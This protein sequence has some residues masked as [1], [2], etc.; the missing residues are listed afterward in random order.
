MVT[1]EQKPQETAEETRWWLRK[2]CFRSKEPKYEGP[3][4]DP[5]QRLEEELE[6][7]P[8][9][10]G[11]SAGEVAVDEVVGGAGVTGCPSGVIRSVVLILNELG[12]H[13]RVLIRGMARAELF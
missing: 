2:E 3:G 13:R 6:E 4:M 1:F 9:A 11:G 8:G 5:A 12:G 7:G 10:G